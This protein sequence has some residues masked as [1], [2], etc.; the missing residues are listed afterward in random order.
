MRWLVLLATV[1][2]VSSAS[3]NSVDDRAHKLRHDPDYKVRL[4][5]AVN[6]GKLGDRR[7]VPALLDAVGD[8]DKTVRGVSAAAL[9]KL[10]D[11]E[12]ATELRERVIVAL[13]RAAEGDGHRLVRSEARRSL[14]AIRRLQAP[15]LRAAGA[16]SI[17]VHV[18]PMADATRQAPRVPALM[19]H[20]VTESLGR[21]APRFATRWANG[22][23]PSQ[24]ELRRSGTTAFYIDGS[25]A[26]LTVSRTPR[27][28]VACAISL[29]L[30]TYPE[31]SLF[32]FMR[33]GAE[34]YAASATDTAL[35]EATSDC[36]A[37]VLDDIVGQR[38]VP[39]IEARLP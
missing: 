22:R 9:G 16:G 10:V 33:G 12:V 1:A 14:E 38:L 18:G 37:A 23:Q 6:L 8:R 26:S 7:A 13:A 30:G 35:A 29:M 31:K 20:K 24:A 5:A 11:A 34:V 21:R 19:R 3:A 17:Y 25:L 4:S 28:H 27:P 2:W 15:P 39:T 32:G 36:V